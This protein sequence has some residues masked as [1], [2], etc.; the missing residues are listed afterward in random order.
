MVQKALGVPFAALLFAAG[1]SHA[2]LSSA[3]TSAV[4][5]YESVGIYWNNPGGTSGC[6]VRFRKSSEGTWRQGL[7]LWYDARN[8]QCRGSLVH[9]EQNTDYEVELNLPGQAASRALSFR[10]WANSLPVART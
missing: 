10:T 8:S 9:L 1:H 5:T 4:P 2:Q 7:D 3:G 6:Q